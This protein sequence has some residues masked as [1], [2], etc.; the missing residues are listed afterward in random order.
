MR[1]E[2]I[3]PFAILF[4]RTLARRSKER[5]ER[6]MARPQTKQV[7]KLPPAAK[8]SQTVVPRRGTVIVI[9][10]ND[11]LQLLI[12]RALKRDGR[13]DMFIVEYVTD[14]LAKG[15]LRA[16]AK[17]VFPDGL[18][19]IVRKTIQVN[20]NYARKLEN[21]TG[22]AETASGGPTWQRAVEIDGCLTPLTVHRADVVA[23]K[24]LTFVPN[25]RAYLRYEPL[26]EKQRN[27]GFGGADFD[28]YEDGH[29]SIVPSASVWPFFFA[30]KKQAVNHRTLALHNVTAVRMDGILYEI[31]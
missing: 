15:K 16:A 9:S 13:G 24:P 6:Q 28:R 3:H 23:E 20:Y 26:T 25:A 17:G 21:R 7:T 19:H 1:L 2:K 4:W 29:G 27:A 18:R 10:R 22:G 11:L 30:R 12:E 31:C 5:K 8:P 14:M